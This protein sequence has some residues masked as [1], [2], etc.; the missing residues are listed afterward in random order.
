[1]K[2]MNSEIQK[3][4][5]NQEAD[6]RE[7]CEVLAREIDSGLPDADSKM[8]EKGAVNSVGLQESGQA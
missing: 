4:N 1:M 7:I 8:A 3:Y 5:E 6:Y 2:E